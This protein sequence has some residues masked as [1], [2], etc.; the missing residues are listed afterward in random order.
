[1]DFGVLILGKRRVDARLLKRWQWSQHMAVAD[2]DSDV[3]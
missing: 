2:S 1:M 3:M